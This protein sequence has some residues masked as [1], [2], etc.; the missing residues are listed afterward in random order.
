MAEICSPQHHECYQIWSA[1]R[2]TGTGIGAAN[3]MKIGSP[4]T[5]FYFYQ[6]LEQVQQR[7]RSEASLVV[8]HSHTGKEMESWIAKFRMVWHAY[9]NTKHYSTHAWSWN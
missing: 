6:D 8:S 4:P 3:G 9:R 7:S 1:Y 2:C 5:N